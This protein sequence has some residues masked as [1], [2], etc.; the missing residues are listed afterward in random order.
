LIDLVLALRRVRHVARSRLALLRPQVLQVVHPAP[1]LVAVDGQ[2]V[3]SRVRLHERL[4]LELLLLVPRHHLP[5][6]ELGDGVREVRR[7]HGLLEA[8]G[9]FVEA[10]RRRVHLEAGELRV[11]EAELVVQL[12]EALG[13]RGPALLE[14]QLPD[15]PQER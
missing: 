4:E 1:P 10:T 9:G 7:H 6:H 13:L 15:V 3:G 2:V 11:D 12:L 5:L 8:R 14:L